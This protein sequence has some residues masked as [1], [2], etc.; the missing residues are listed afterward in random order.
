MAFVKLLLH[1]VETQKNVQN[2]VLRA[3]CIL[4]IHTRRVIKTLV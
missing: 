2:D 3:S 4:Q 1:N